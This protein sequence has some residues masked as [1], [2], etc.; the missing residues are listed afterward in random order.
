MYIP[1]AV[2]HI[3]TYK[4]II[5][6]VWT[7]FRGDYNLYPLLNTP[8][9]IKDIWIEDILNW[10]CFIDFD[11]KIFPFKWTIKGGKNWI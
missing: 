9:I 6:D 2:G 8:L 10:I 1:I 5:I 7:Y 11:F 3:H 4:S